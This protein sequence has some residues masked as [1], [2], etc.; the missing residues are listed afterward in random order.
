M[1]TLLALA[2]LA[3]L[4]PQTS[5]A[6]VDLLPVETTVAPREWYLGGVFEAQ[7]AEGF[8]VTESGSGQ[9]H[10]FEVR[11]VGEPMDLVFPALKL[12]CAPGAAA[13]VTGPEFAEFLGGNVRDY[14]ASI[15]MEVTVK[16]DLEL[17]IDGEARPGQRFHLGPGLTAAGPGLEIDVLVYQS[18]ENLIGMIAKA[19]TLGDQDSRSMAEQVRST[20]KVKPVTIASARLVQVGNFTV[21]VPVISPTTW[22]RPDGAAFLSIGVGGGNFELGAQ[23]GLS[24]EQA[25]AIGSSYFVARKQALEESINELGGTMLDTRWA[26]EWIQNG[27]LLGFH[28]DF[29]QSDG[30][31]F[32]ISSF[33]LLA[34]TD[35][36]TATV[37]VPT[38]ELPLALPRFRDMLES[39]QCPGNEEALRATFGRT[40]LNQ[41]HGLTLYYPDT[42]RL[43]QQ[44]G[45]VVQLTLRGKESLVPSDLAMHLFVDPSPQRSGGLEAFVRETIGAQFPGAEPSAASAI[46]GNL[47]GQ[48][49]PGLQLTWTLDGKSFLATALSAPLHDG[50][51]IALATSRLENSSSS[52]WSF[53]NILAGMEQLDSGDRWIQSETYDVV[54]DPAAWTVNSSHVGLGSQFRFEHK[55][56]GLGVTF[57]DTSSPLELNKES[58][59]DSLVGAANHYFKIQE[60]WAGTAVTGE[61]SQT[62]EVLDQ[63][64]DAID[65]NG[66]TCIRKRLNFALPSGEAY[67]LYLYYM[68]TE[69]RAV[70]AHF[71]AK[72]TDKEGLEAGQ[73]LVETLRI[74]AGLGVTEQVQILGD[75]RIDLPLGFVRDTPDK[76]GPESLYFWNSLVDGAF[77]AVARIP[78]AGLPDYQELWM[79][80]ENSIRA[81]VDPGLLEEL[82][83][84]VGEL[85]F[86]G[87][88]REARIYQYT[89]LDSK[90]Q[91][92]QLKSIAQVGPWTY[93]LTVVGPQ[94][95]RY[96]FDKLQAVLEGASLVATWQQISEQGYNIAYDP[97]RASLSRQELP[98][99][100]MEGFLFQGSGNERLFT[101]TDGKWTGSGLDDPVFLSGINSTLTSQFDLGA[102]KSFD[103]ELGT[104][105]LT[106]QSST[107]TVKKSIQGGVSFSNQTPGE[108]LYISVK[109]LGP[110]NLPEALM[111][112]SVL[113]DGAY[114]IENFHL[115]ERDVLGARAAGHMVSFMDGAGQRYANQKFVV[116]VPG[117]ALELF[118][119]WAPGA[120]DLGLTQVNLFFDSL[121]LVE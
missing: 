39:L 111:E 55:S 38:A 103:L 33:F 70:V 92:V 104:T 25:Q 18:G 64:R 113:N 42:L 23:Q 56:K 57:Q 22:N 52:S 28:M 117:G 50:T 72:A 51:L 47:L 80:A 100:S 41:A 106:L 94:E 31:A 2:T 21:E 17:V 29:V 59:F 114:T 79:G 3:S 98:G 82:T 116:P 48:R 26:G 99:G 76:V 62:F 36:F 77:A 49:Q 66:V 40:S 19:E 78:S 67:V 71:W 75:L 95:S 102:T 112:Q 74:R 105:K 43:E 27:Q 8:E 93:E 11:R 85:L 86:L 7:I 84:Q 107:N 5:Q 63:R 15:S 53:A 81:G 34:G 88:R 46:E 73:R 101:V 96:E 32:T 68:I 20:L 91:Q 9:V 10:F 115:V 61:R 69:Q 90:E 54:F 60:T 13:N 121:E 35:L 30:A 4:G 119:T 97:A 45:D 120:K 118:A 16:E 24:E 87:H 6:P 110:V 44:L 89:P 12:L 83:T 108:G 109:F 14:A 1:L 58:P 37:T 65:I